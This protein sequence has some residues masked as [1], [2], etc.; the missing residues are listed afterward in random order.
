MADLFW[1]SEAQ[2]AAIEPFVPEH[3]PG[4]VRKGDRQVISDI[5]HV[6]ASGCRWR[7]CPAAHGK[8]TTVHDRFDRRSRRGFRTAMLSALAKA[9]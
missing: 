8:R 2:G 5:L 1:P 7:D 6:L 3:Q 9:G 4:P